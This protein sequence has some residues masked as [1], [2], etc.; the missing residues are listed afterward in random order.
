METLVGMFGATRYHQVS[1]YSDAGNKFAIA[2]FS[3][4]PG[5][6]ATVK[7]EINDIN[8]GWKYRLY[9]EWREDSYGESFTFTSFEPLVPKSHDGM[10]DF[11]SRLVP[12]IGPVRGRLIVDHFGEDSFA[13]LKEN[14]S[15]LK[16]VDGI[17]PHVREAVEAYF[18]ADNAMQVDPVAYSRLY[19]LLKSIKPRR[20]VIMSLLANFGSNAP[21]FITENPYRLLDYPGMGWLSVDKLA[22]KI[23]GYRED[24]LE[25]HKK[26]IFESLSRNAELGHTKVDSATLQ[27]D[28]AKLLGM[29]LLPAAISEAED[30]RMT[31]TDEKGYVSL[32]KIYMYEILISS[33]LARLRG[34]S[35]LGFDLSDDMFEDEQRLIPEMVRTKLVSG[36]SG[37]PGSGKSHS[38]SIIIKNLIRHGES[39]ILVVAPTGKAAKRNDEL[40]QDLNLDTSIICSTMHRALGAQM[41]GDAEVGIPEE[42]ARV[43][44]GREK[45]Q[46]EYGAANKLPYSV[47][48]IDECSMVDVQLGS[49]FLSAIPTG[50]RVI[51]VGDRYQLPSVGPGSVLRDIIAAGI[52]I[53]NLDKPRRNSGAI[54]QACY[55]IKE[56]RNPD[57]IALGEKFSK[58]WTHVEISKDENIARVI[59]EIHSNYININNFDMSKSNLQVISPEKKGILGCYYLNRVL[60]DI[61]NPVQGSRLATGKKEDTT[62][63]AAVRIGDKV[64]RTKNGQVNSLIDL[65]TSFDYEMEV[66]KTIV[67]NNIEYGLSKAYVVNGDM[68][69]VVGFHGALVVVRFVNPARLCIMSKQESKIS[70]AYALTVHKM[71]GSSAPI[72]I[73]PLSNFY[74]NSRDMVGLFCRE[75][76]YTMFSRPS[77][78]LITVGRINEAYQAISRITINQR[79]TRLRELLLN[80]ELIPRIHIEPE[81]IEE[82]EESESAF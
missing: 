73:V 21:Q 12:E 71:Q 29:Q 5:K 33:E 8:Y 51:I 54:A 15:R 59:S 27:Y 16:E 38:I 25:R 18:S 24:G 49:M 57:P 44:R 30:E 39:N 4:D 82:F 23:L 75:L 80:P 79:Q 74:W 48:I 45:F 2:E 11:M 14:P 62:S 1:Q 65:E 50:S 28:C 17:S 6:H 67:F 7:G 32:R 43:N 19:D 34:D 68:G 53:V 69:E 37:V 36:I 52:P 22:T 61:V 66:T 55:M 26:A 72:V 70:L 63:E 10:V 46:F 35:D 20:K 3:T 81:P 41:S 77:E 31:Y 9:G 58:N 47:Y 56:G 40:I 78:R 13:I 64:V 60:G 42:E 76:I